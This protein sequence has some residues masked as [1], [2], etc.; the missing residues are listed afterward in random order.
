MTDDV[1]DLEPVEPDMLP[2]A[3][4]APATIDAALTSLIQA[5]D[6]FG[7]GSPD[8]WIR[9]V[10]VILRALRAD[11]RRYRV[12][13]RAPTGTYDQVVATAPRLCNAITTLEREHSRIDASL[14]RLLQWIDGP[15]ASILHIRLRNNGLT[16]VQDLIRYRQ[17]G[18]DLLHQTDELD[19][20]GQG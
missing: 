17:Q 10:R 4:T 2:A 11:L 16:L 18:A 13:L 6:G 19:L 8:A 7:T 15:H 9:R 14:D 1:H 20:G 5:L 3:S 12:V